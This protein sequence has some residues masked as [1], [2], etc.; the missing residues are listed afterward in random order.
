M[1]PKFRELADKERDAE[2]S[3]ILQLKKDA[4]KIHAEIAMR[5]ER[6]TALDNLLNIDVN[7]V[8]PAISVAGLGFRDAVRAILRESDNTGFTTREIRELLKVC[9]YVYKAETPISI[10]ISNEVRRMAQQG[11]MVKQGNKYL[12]TKKGWNME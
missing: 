6:L 3:T 4:T 11:M 2:I 10:R 9:G 7:D 5:Q 1:D 12:L 8:S